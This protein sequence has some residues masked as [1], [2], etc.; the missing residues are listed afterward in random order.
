[1]TEASLDSQMLESSA[2][3]SKELVTQQNVLSNIEATE[4]REA[5]YL[6]NQRDSPFLRLPAELRNTIYNYV[7]G[8]LAIMAPHSSSWCR[9][10]VLSIRPAPE[11]LW[12]FPR[13]FLSIVQSCRQAYSESARLPFVLNT[14]DA[15][16]SYSFLQFV[17]NLPE[18]QRNEISMI[19]IS[20]NEAYDWSVAEQYEIVMGDDFIRHM[21]YHAAHVVDRSTHRLLLILKG[22]K[23][24]TV[25]SY[26]DL[27]WPEDQKNQELLSK[28]KSNYRRM[29]EAM[30][31]M[32]MELGRDSVSVTFE[33]YVK[34]PS[35]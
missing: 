17:E 21:R 14:F 30:A 3:M 24:L 18:W 35:H 29:M 12:Q 33:P 32:K 16:P 34:H 28:A 4:A 9:I 11:E 22:L 27:D 8:G 23:L 31:W 25:D 20:C 10:Q 2:A 6:K 26:I 13:H 5:L 1:M 19:R 7:L 15:Y